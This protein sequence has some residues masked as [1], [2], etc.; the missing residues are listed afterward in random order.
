MSNI[1]QTTKRADDINTATAPHHMLIVN[2]ESTA[3][4]ELNVYIQK[5][6]TK[7][8]PGS[9]AAR[10]MENRHAK[11]TDTYGTCALPKC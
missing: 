10:K 4:A 6:A 3:A 11:G 7:H 9:T 1:D 2:P 5:M 8:G